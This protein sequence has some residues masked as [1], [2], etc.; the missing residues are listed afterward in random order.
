[1]MSKSK[2]RPGWRRSASQWFLRDEAHKRRQVFRSFLAQV[3][4]RTDYAEIIEPHE[5]E[6][7]EYW[8]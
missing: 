7:K 8:D 4:K 3:L 1:M 6:M 2:Y 5:R